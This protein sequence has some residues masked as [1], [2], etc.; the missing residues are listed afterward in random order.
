MRKLIFFISA[1]FVFSQP[2]TAQE[3]PV[4]MDSS[5][6][7]VVRLSEKDLSAYRS[8][9][10]FDYKD[11]ENKGLSLWDRFWIWVWDTID[12]LFEKKS[13]RKGANIFVWTLSILLILYAIYRFTGMERRYFFRSAEPS[14]INFREA[15]EDIRNM[16]LPAA[17]AAAEQEGNYRLALRLQYLN[18]LKQLYAKKLIGYA[19]NKTN[20][21]YA[22]ELSGSRYSDSFAR[23]TLLYEFGWYG[24]FSVD[25]D[26]YQKIREIFD[27]HQ[28][29]VQS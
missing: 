17:I 22:R 10:D 3:K 7:D 21:D 1:F 5:G 18:S 15:E 16:D 12:K 24:E 19:M 9:S 23:I 28:K 20:H 8:D 26:M 25:R 13:V 4:L 14:T 27:D 11:N 6:T 2:L 29:M